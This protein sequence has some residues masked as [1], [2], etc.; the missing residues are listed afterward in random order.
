[1]FAH[2]DSGDG[3]ALMGQ[4]VEKLVPAST[5]VVFLV[6]EEREE[7][8]PAAVHGLLPELFEDMAI[9]IGEGA[10]GWVVAQNEA[11]I[12]GAASLDVARK[13]KPTDNLEL[14]STL[15]VPLPL[16]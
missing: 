9:K 2:G 16:W 11:L 7:L 10:S 13:L 5:T 14:T 8:R 4:K 3:R 6:D 15:S 1:M 12:N